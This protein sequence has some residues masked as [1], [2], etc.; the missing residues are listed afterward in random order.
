MNLPIMNGSEVL[1]E[2]RRQEHLRGIPVVMLTSSLAEKDILESYALG[3]SCYVNK[4]VDLDAF[5]TIVQTISTFWFTVSRTVA[6]APL[7]YARRTAPN[8][9]EI[10]LKT[11]IAPRTPI[12]VLLVEDNPGDADLVREAME[13]SKLMIALDVVIDGEE[14]VS[15]LT[16]EAR[17]ARGELPDL[18]LLDINLPKMNGRQVLAEVKTHQRLRS[19]PIVMLTSSEADKDVGESYALGANCYVSKPVD[20]AAFQTIVRSIETFWFTVVRLP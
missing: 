7:T 6:A 12:R 1:A 8:Q 14:A 11:H 16:D 10:E 15:Y 17:A 19:I 9:E 13:S 3:A 5:Q 20:L 18:V 4:P 2:I